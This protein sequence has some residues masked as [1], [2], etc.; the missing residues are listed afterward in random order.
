MVKP[1]PAGTSLPTITFSFNPSKE[2]V[3][4]FIEASVKTL[5]VSWKE[6]AEINELVCKEALVIPNKTLSKIAGFFCSLL[7]YH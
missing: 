7:T 3:L 1:V 4:P 6:A 2:S 5:V